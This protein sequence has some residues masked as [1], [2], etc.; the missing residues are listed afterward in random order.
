MANLRTNNLCGRGFVSVNDGTIWS[1]LFDGSTLN[2]YPATN[3][4]DGSVSTFTYAA[5]GTTLTWTAPNGGI[6]SGRIEVYVYAGNTH[7]IVL[8]NG[9]STGAVVGADYEQQGNWVDVTSLVGGNLKTITCF[10]ETIGGVARQSGFSAVRINGEILVDREYGITGGKQAY[11][12]SVFFE[13]VSSYL[14]MGE[15]TLI[16]SATGFGTNDFTIEFWINQGVNNSNYTIIFTLHTTTAKGFEVA[17]HSGTIQ[18]YTDTG[19]WRDTGY[20]PI[21]GVYEHIAFV[22]NYSGN[23]LKM[24]VNGEEKYSV[25]NN[26]D[27]SDNFD[28]VQIGSY[29][30]SA[31]GYFEGYISNFRI[32]NG[33]ALYTTNYFSPPTSELKAIPN[34][35]LLCCQDSDDPTKEETGKTITAA[36]GRFQT[37]S[38]NILKNGNFAD[39][40]DGFIGDSGASISES[41]GVMTVTNGGGD[42]LY[43]LAQQR[44]LRIGGKYR[45]TATVTPTF[46]S[47]NPVFRVRFG[48][49]NV[50]FTQP[51][52]TMSTG[53]AVRIDTGEKVADGTTFE[54]GSG[55]SSGI[56]QFTVTDLVVTAIDPPIPIKNIPPFGV[57]AGNTFGGPIQQSTQGYMC[58]PTGRTEERGRGRGIFHG[59]YNYPSSGSYNAA[60]SAVEIASDGVT[61]KFGD[62]SQTRYTVGTVGS[63]TRSV[64]IGGASPVTSPASHPFYTNNIIDFVTIAT[65]G[66]TQE[67]GDSDEPGYFKTG[68]SSNTRGVYTQGRQYTPSAGTGSAKME[69]ITIATKGDG[70]DFGD[71]VGGGRMTLCNAAMSPTRGILAGGVVTPGGS[72]TTFTNEIEFVTMAT[73]GNSVE[74]GDLDKSG[75]GG[76][77]NGNCSSNTRGV[78]NLGTQSPADGNVIEFITIATTGNAKNFGDLSGGMNMRGACSNQIRGLFAGGF[79]SPGSANYV[80]TCEKITIA[81]TGSASDWGETFEGVKRGYNSGISDSHGGL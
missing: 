57:D 81:T 30:A 26:V 38:K 61:S 41:G 60:L 73:L 34:T 70:Q 50:S 47:G 77:S 16:G 28:Y 19:S 64:F 78:M 71:M 21:A 56:T 18:I 39:G 11:R 7:P 2:S 58:F 62:L 4:F 52:A 13:G 51:Q 74:F 65:K 75:G 29:D 76:R 49:S 32:L 20:A 46:A 31:Y 53:V 66:N 63:S 79:V 55:E 67:F 1:S 69:F 6:K 42:N 17:F 33:T 12:G 25:S 10:G 44:C 48:G 5:A 14:Y 9:V 80:N 35:I 3:A 36:G 40:T 72:P 27:Y 59:G 54:I 24:Y 45:C 43:A 15:D 8:V 68:V 37:G 22:R 23:T